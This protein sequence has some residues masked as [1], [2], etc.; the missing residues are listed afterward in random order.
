MLSKGC[1]FSVFV[2]TG[3]NDSDTLSVDVYSLKTEKMKKSL[4]VFESTKNIR[5]RVDWA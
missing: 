2:W 3:E 1:C 4:A 5:I